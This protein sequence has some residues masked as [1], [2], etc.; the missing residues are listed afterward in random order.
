MSEIDTDPSGTIYVQT[1]HKGGIAVYP[2]EV[3]HGPDMADVFMRAAFRMVP[4]KSFP[5]FIRD[6]KNLAQSISQRLDEFRIGDD[7]MRF[8]IEDNDGGSFLLCVGYDIE[9]EFVH[10]HNL[11]E[12]NYAEGNGKVEL[13]KYDLP[14]DGGEAESKPME[15]AY[16]LAVRHVPG[17]MVETVNQIGFQA[18]FPD[19]Q[20][21]LAR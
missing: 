20:R 17:I 10:K 14:Q 18:Y 21:R 2:S 16:D 12:I 19:Q 9:D 7:T 8:W 13:I 4:E 11:A 5:M 3:S 15:L 6:L 1:R